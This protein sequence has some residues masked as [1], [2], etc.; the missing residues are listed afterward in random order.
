LRRRLRLPVLFV[1]ACL[2]AVSPA[3]SAAQ[4]TGPILLEGEA[5]TPSYDLVLELGGGGMVT[6]A[7]EGSDEYILTPWPIVS[8]DVLRLPGLLELGGGPAGGFSV[9]PS[10]EL[11]A[12]RDDEDY[13]GL[14]G[15]GDVERAYELGAG[16]SYQHEFLR[17]FA[18]LRRGF[19]G[20]EG[21]V[22][23]TGVDAIAPLQP[24]LTLSAGPRL[25]FASQDYM[26][27]YF[28]VTPRQAARSGLPAYRADAGLKSV[29]AEAKVRYEF[30]ADWAVTAKGGYYRLVGDAADSRIA[31][32]GDR[33]Q[34][35]AGLGLSRRFSFDLFD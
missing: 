34:F 13:D 12:A 11:R 21:L 7:Y 17:G 22:G 19:G 18:E 24:D 15:L 33:N 16:I 5:A 9:F 10:F 31:E 14:R 32:R 3:I 20:H 2:P 4:D 35:S 30:A 6:P 1:S 29:G 26:D 23:E 27:T 25:T 8:L 28:G